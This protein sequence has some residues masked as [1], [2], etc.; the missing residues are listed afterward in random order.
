L[1]REAAAGL[2]VV[3]DAQIQTQVLQADSCAPRDCLPRGGKVGARRE[4]QAKR[5]GKALEA[6]RARHLVEL[7]Q[8]LREI[9]DPHA[10]RHGLGHGILAPRRRDRACIDGVSVR[11][12]LRFCCNAPFVK[13]LSSARLWFVCR[14]SPEQTEMTSSRSRRTS[15][16]SSAPEVCSRAQKLIGTGQSAHA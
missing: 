15:L 3:V 16:S 13:S 1:Q 6:V 2:P 10:Q 12:R 7:C 8:T 11:A 4:E 9:G 14:A 5:D